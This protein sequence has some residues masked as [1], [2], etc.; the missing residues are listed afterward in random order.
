MPA[1]I[2]LNRPGKPLRSPRG[3]KP[4]QKN[5]KK[6][7]PTV[8]EPGEAIVRPLTDADVVE[9]SRVIRIRKDFKELCD[10]I[11]AAEGSSGAAV[12]NRMVQ[13]GLMAEGFLKPVRE[14]VG[15]RLIT[16]DGTVVRIERVPPTN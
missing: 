12:L 5:K 14:I 8:P 10:S 4:G 15:E 9:T 1:T 2:D 16:A 3:R 11:A 13:L 7:G 6:S